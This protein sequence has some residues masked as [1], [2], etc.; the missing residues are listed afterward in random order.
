MSTM[1]DNYEIGF[2]SGGQLR[3]HLNRISSDGHYSIAFFNNHITIYSI[4]SR[5]P[6]RSFYT[7]PALNFNSIIDTYIS[8]INTNLIYILTS[9]TVFILNW[10]DNLKDPLISKIKLNRL[11]DEDDLN[12]FEPLKIINFNSNNETILNLLVK[13]NKKL[14]IIS[15]DINENKLIKIFKIFSNVST[16][17]ISNNYKNLV[18]AINKGLS[19]IYSTS[20]FEIFSFDDNNESE[21]SSF[22]INVSDQNQIIS[23]KN[24][25][26]IVNLAISN[27]QSD[28]LL[29][30]SLS[31]GS[32]ILLFELMSQK[33]TQ[34][35][36]K[37]HID[38]VKSLTFNNDT[39]Y[40][41]SG[42]SEKVLVFWNII[43]EKQQF[44]P[45]LNGLIENIQIDS[46]IPTLINLTLNVIDNDYQYLILSTTDLLSKLDI[47][48][49]HLF[50]GLNKNNELKKNFIKD[51][52]SFKKSNQFSRFKH[53][54]N[55]SFK[56]HS[57]SNYL[58]LPAGRHL[59]IFD[60]LH[61]NQ[62]DNFAIAP[63][64]QQYGKVGNENKI[65]DPTII[66]F[67]FINSF[68]TNEKDWL[69]TCD[70]EIRGEAED[71]KNSS[72]EYW[73]TLRFWK[74]S[75]N[76]KQQNDVIS[77]NDS[78]SLQTKIL[79]PHNEFQ[80]TSIVP[81]PSTYFGGEAVLTADSCGN[82]RLWRPNSQGIWSLRKFFSSGSE[83]NTSFNNN[84]NNG[85]NNNSKKSDN[86]SNIANN[87]GTICAWSPDSSMIAIAR[88]GKVVLLD[89][90]TFEPIHTIK[91]SISA[92][93]FHKHA[94]I[95][96]NDDNNNNNNDNNNSN[97]KTYNNNDKTDKIRYIDINLQDKHILSINFTSNGKL[98]VIETRTHLTVVNILKN[99][100][101]FGLLLSD[102][103]SNS[104]FGGSFVKLIS[105]NK[106]D[107][108]DDE[109]IDLDNDTTDELMIIGKYFHPNQKIFSKISL[110]NI[111][112]KKSTIKC[113]WCHNHQGAIIGAE[114]SDSWQKWIMAD[115]NS[116]LGEISYGKSYSRK[117]LL[118]DLNKKQEDNWIVSSLL[119]NARIMNRATTEKNNENSKNNNSD[120][121][122]DRVGLKSSSFEGILD[123]LEGV[124]VESL[125][126]RVLRVV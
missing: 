30:I 40:L 75:N 22:I 42:G 36:L 83:F 2:S 17:A 98:L 3:S 61:N 58:Y 51:I 72:I 106:N 59:Q 12:I 97:D 110:W 85:H 48:T 31:N 27:D 60:H 20:Q 126:E 45:R 73:E 70:V 54:Y 33:Q 52:H 108:N 46:K 71:L 76:S 34:R 67:E 63:A 38:P 115:S 123:H 112:D 109:L 92:S 35:L 21:L 1:K 11:I 111:S 102:D 39:T 16:F 77:I 64:I 5:L 13:S 88:N 4:Q 79:R 113:K 23:T 28:P 119:D 116:I 66:G 14:L 95:E 117:K 62:I 24:I 32:I 18:F 47:N 65:S 94:S 89:V 8:P 93:R 6:I 99:T 105:R 7:L 80:I 10:Y 104:G 120:E 69:I 55:S 9:T 100:I 121:F 118:N 53:N 124:S 44:L 56:I 57:K 74:Y 125:F 91:P 50:A 81:A 107:L 49:P 96:E 101:I 37:W 82:V 86:L 19:L 41:L 87:E 78:W 15:F 103:D 90:N 29:A 25:I 114:W 68:K 26:N 84:S 122:N 43:N